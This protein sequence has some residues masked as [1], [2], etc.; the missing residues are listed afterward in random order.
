MN[1]RPITY[2]DDLTS[3]KK[4]KIEKKETEEEEEEEISEE[5]LPESE[6]EEERLGSIS[7]FFEYASEY[8]PWFLAMNEAYRKFRQNKPDIKDIEIE[9]LMVLMRHAFS[10]I[11][12][13]GV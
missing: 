5:E 1:K 6:D 11:D 13:N 10:H 4:I 3:Q 9:D 2:D 7:D 12:E 8:D